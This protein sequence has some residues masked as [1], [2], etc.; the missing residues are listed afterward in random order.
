MSEGKTL[1]YE[2]TVHFKCNAIGSLDKESDCPGYVEKPNSHG[3]CQFRG[4]EDNCLHPTAKLNC[5][6][7]E[8]IVREKFPSG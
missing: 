4:H 7:A 5:A 2:A 3:R 1:H 6:E 8:K